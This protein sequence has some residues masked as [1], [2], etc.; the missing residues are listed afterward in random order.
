MKITGNKWYWFDVISDLKRVGLEDFQISELHPD[1]MLCKALG[2]SF[3][4]EWSYEK[5]CILTL[6]KYSP[7]IIEAFCELLE[8]DPT[9]VYEK[10]NLYVVE[11]EQ[12]NPH[13]RIAQLKREYIGGE[14]KNPKQYD[15]L[16]G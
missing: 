2:I 1:A 13:G 16:G 12:E 3:W 4:L 8:V 15:Y 14:I 7:G 6:S 5:Y 9:V 10:N 11:F